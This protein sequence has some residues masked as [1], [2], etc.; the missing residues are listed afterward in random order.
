MEGW[1][2]GGGLL[3]REGGYGG[4]MVEGKGLGGGG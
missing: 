4:G 1:E 3:L 2:G